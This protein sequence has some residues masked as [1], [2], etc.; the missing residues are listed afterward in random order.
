MSE[1]VKPRRR[2]RSQL[3]ERQAAATRQSILDAARE[4]IAETGFTGATIRGIAERAGVAKETVYGAFGSKGGILSALGAMNIDRAATELLPE[5]GLAALGTLEDAGRQL[6]LFAELS[7][8]IMG[9]NWA[10]VEALRVG[11]AT[12]PELAALYRQ[13][14]D[15]RRA[16]MR[17]LVESLERGGRL[18]QEID[19]E[20]AIDTLWALTAPELYRLLAVERSWSDARYA[21]W[22]RNAAE[23]LLL[24]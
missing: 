3:R 22:V 4:L 15:G 5:G 1:P 2:Y 8:R 17:A 14:S 9:A 7:A 6:D 19:L 20:D 24:A 11:G 21:A 12:D 18:R 13:A 16:W 23:R 10:M